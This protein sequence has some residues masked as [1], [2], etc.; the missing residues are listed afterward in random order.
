MTNHSFMTNDHVSRL[1]HLHVNLQTT[2]INFEK[3]LG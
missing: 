3:L 1:S 2:D